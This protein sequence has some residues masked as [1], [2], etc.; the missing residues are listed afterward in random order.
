MDD[1][2]AG[3]RQLLYLHRHGKLSDE[4]LRRGLALIDRPRDPREWGELSSRVLAAMG[5]ALIAVAVI[6]F[7][8]YNWDQLERGEAFVA[9]QVALG[10]V[11]GVVLWRGPQSAAGFGA[12]LGAFL[13]IGA[14]LALFG[15]TYQTGRDPWQLF[16]GW[17]ALS[18]PLVAV[19]RSSA[20]AVMAVEVGAVALALWW[21][22]QGPIS[23]DHT[24]DGLLLLSFWH[25]LPCLGWE[26]GSLR[27]TLPRWPVWIWMFFA[28]ILPTLGTGAWM[29]AP[30]L[31]EAGWVVAGAWAGLTL[32]QL[33]RGR[34]LGRDRALLAM[35]GAGILIQVAIQGYIIVDKLKLESPLDFLAY[36]GLGLVLSGLAA[37]LSWAV[38]KGG[39]A[40]S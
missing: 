27:L 18:V 5:A 10:L 6:Y 26:L 11:V 22:L 21:R 12:S 9:V 15:Q 1:Q 28:W 16:A 39:E 13:L 17:A 3:A 20:L 19:G 33:V 4:A 14:S 38:W 7:F 40:S 30:R 8:A 25:L 37:T 34:L 2:P 35:A 32:L 31:Y 23:L 24:R 29:L 36:G